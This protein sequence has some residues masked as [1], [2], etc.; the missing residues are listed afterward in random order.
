MPTKFRPDSFEY[1]GRFGSRKATR[2]KNY[3]KGTP[4][5]ELFEYINSPSSKPKTIQK[6]LNELA[7]RDIKITRTY[8]EQPDLSSIVGK[9]R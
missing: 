7:R 8:L 5:E 9:L 1:A 4:K 3:I 6:C 2:I